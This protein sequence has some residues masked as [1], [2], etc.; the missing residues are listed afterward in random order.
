MKNYKKIQKT[1]GIR[2]AEIALLSTQRHSWEQGTAMQAFLEMGEEDIVI[3]MAFEA[4]NRMAEDGRV[5]TI[6]VTDAITDPCSLGEGLIYACERTGDSFLCEGRDQLLEWAL[7]KAPR[8]EEGILYHLTRTKEFWSDSFYML[9]PFLA[10]AGY[11]QEGLKQW[12]GYWRA[13]YDEKAGLL[14]HMWD[15]EKKSFS[16]AAHWGTGN[17]WALASIARMIGL[18]P[19]EEFKE[20]REELAGK[21]RLLLDHL[22][23]LWKRD[24]RFYDV[25]DNPESFEET[26]LCQ[27]TAY[28]IYRGISQ[29]WL[30][31][32]CKTFGD[33][34]RKRAGEKM[35]DY[36]FIREACGAP[37]FNKP[38]YSPEAQA[39]Y[40]LMESAFQSV[41]I[42]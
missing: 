13:L 41:G 3:A 39:F 2:K 37:D 20:E 21:G 9:P 5:A 15:D 31:A 33:E 18:L 32:S 27:M 35:N 30:D 6:G 26:N 19:E 14:C 4:V 40:L 22:L 8:N 34:M 24:G 17:G 7:K 25:V 10:A 1:E 36:G 11:Y 23:I 16:R 29:G 12:N 38:G 28:T 42:L